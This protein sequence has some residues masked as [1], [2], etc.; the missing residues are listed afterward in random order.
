MCPAC[1]HV[2]A[3]VA[4][5]HPA[6]SCAA[7]SPLVRV[8]S[9]RDIKL[10]GSSAVRGSSGL[11]HVLNARLASRMISL[12]GTRGRARAWPPTIAGREVEPAPSPASGYLPPPS[13]EREDIA[14]TVSPPPVTSKTV[15]ARCVEMKWASFLVRDQDHALLAA[16][17][18][19]SLAAVDFASKSSQ[20]TASS[21]VLEGKS[22]T[23]R[24]PLLALSRGDVSRRLGIHRK[25][26]A[27]GVEHPTGIL[28]LDLAPA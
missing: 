16:G 10:R 9:A 25:V 26:G 12:A 20:A 18:Q 21:L 5:D 27:L 1:E 4:E 14:I 2:E 19:Q 3:T 7:T 15:C 6:T 11:P 24:R 8:A 28:P 23:A 22:A 17:H 13:P